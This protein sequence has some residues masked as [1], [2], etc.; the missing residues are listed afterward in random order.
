M[1]PLPGPSELLPLP[2]PSSPLGSLHL[3]WPMV[4][5]ATHA[6]TSSAVTSLLTS[7]SVHL[8]HHLPPSA[9]MPL[10]PLPGNWRQ[11][12]PPCSALHLPQSSYSLNSYQDQL[13]PSE[14][15]LGASHHFQIEFQLPRMSL[16][17]LHWPAP[18]MSPTSAL[19]TPHVL[20]TVNSLC[21]S[22]TMCVNRDMNIYS[23]SIA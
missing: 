19:P 5:P 4:C 2:E 3:E 18:S 9:L 15:P 21:S 1:F 13:L 20:A 8:S 23:H 7:A 6:E 12:L 11:S 10:G 16:K 14:S 22:H 17:V